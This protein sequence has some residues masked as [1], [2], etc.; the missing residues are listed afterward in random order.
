MYW[1][2]RSIMLKS[3]LFCNNFPTCNVHAEILAVVI[4]F[5]IKYDLISGIAVPFSF[6][7]VFVFKQ[8]KKNKK[9]KRVET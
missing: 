9:K 1:F 4:I 8:P 3:F 7:P 2:S 6:Q 5:S